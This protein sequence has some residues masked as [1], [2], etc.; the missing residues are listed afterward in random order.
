MKSKVSGDLAFR[1]ASD[2][3]NADVGGDRISEFRELLFSAKFQELC[4]LVAE[5]DMWRTHR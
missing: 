4:F 5:T 3:I 1:K 2:K